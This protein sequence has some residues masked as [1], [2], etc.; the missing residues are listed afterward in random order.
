MQRKRFR[1]V[2]RGSSEACPWEVGPGS[3]TQKEREVPLC[4]ERLFSLRLLAVLKL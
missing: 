4:R 2:A 3:R 1:E